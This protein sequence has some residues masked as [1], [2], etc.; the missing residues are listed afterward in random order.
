ATYATLPPG[1]VTA[2]GNRYVFATIDG[3]NPATLTFTSTNASK[4]YGDVAGISS[5]FAVS[6]FQT[7]VANAFLT[8]TASTAYSGSPNLTS[9]GTAATATVAGS[10]YTI[11]IAAG[12]PASRRGYGVWFV[13]A[14]A[15]DREPPPLAG[16]AFDATQ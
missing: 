10:P 14:G 16:A 9:S 12:S 1:S 2:S 13:R 6:G 5:N 4:T 11:N 8:D 15:P 3:T 7:G